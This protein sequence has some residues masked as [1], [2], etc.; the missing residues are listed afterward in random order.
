MGTKSCFKYLIEHH[1]KL[2]WEI[3]LGYDTPPVSSRPKLLVIS[4]SIDNLSP[5]FLS[6]IQQRTVSDEPLTILINTI[7]KWQYFGQKLIIPKKAF[8]LE[9]ISPT[10]I[11]QLLQPFGLSREGL[12]IVSN[13]L[14][15]LY[16]GRIEYIQEVLQNQ[17][18]Y[19]LRTIPI[20]ELHWINIPSS[21]SCQRHQEHMLQSV[22]KP[23]LPVLTALLILM[24]QL[25]PATFVS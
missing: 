1:Q 5:S 13:R 9:P 19:S 6:D 7:D 22:S 14:N 16:K 3:H 12:T 2:G 25:Q 17:W 20:D 24:D 23:V 10:H 4:G 21:P 8:A 15:E 18:V 11:Q